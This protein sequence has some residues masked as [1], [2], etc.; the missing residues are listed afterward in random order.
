M[1]QDFTSAL[2]QYP[3]HINVILGVLGAI[4]VTQGILKFYHYTSSTKSLSN[5][6]YRFATFFVSA[7]CFIAVFATSMHFTR[8]AIQNKRFDVQQTET[9]VVVNSHSDW[10]K[11]VEFEIGNDTDGT[12]YLT[13]NNK[14]Y[15]LN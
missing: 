15:S 9:S 12:T 3:T 4:A 11:S 6:K 13:Y 14:A 7:V 2:V 5:S 8:D 1:I 10:L